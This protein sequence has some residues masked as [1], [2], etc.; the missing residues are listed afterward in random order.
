M[1][2]LFTSEAVSE[3][4]PDKVADQISDAILDAFL[5]KDRNSHVACE[6]M[7]T[8]GLVV[9]SGEIK[10]DVQVMLK[11]LCEIQSLILAIMIPN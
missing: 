3:G 5:S 9:L 8:T 2:R 1:N 7:V 11:K 6:T 4:H 10:S